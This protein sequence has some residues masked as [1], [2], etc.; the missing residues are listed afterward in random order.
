M[1]FSVP[2]E[3]EVK[4]DRQYDKGIGTVLIVSLEPSG[5][6]IIWICSSEHLGKRETQIACTLCTRK[7]GAENHITGH[8]EMLA[9]HRDAETLF[10]ST[11]S[12]AD[13]SHS[14][15]PSQAAVCYRAHAPLQDATAEMIFC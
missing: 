8:E 14:Q 1:L 6:R 4:S 3:L 2:I 9:M 5:V 10:E 15:E 11:L 13:K 12:H 7:T